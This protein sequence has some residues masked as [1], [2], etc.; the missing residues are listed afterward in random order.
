MD[1]KVSD[2]YIIHCLERLFSPMAKQFIMHNTNGKQNKRALRSA[3]SLNSNTSLT[4]LIGQSSHVSPAKT[5]RGDRGTG[6]GRE[7]G[8]KLKRAKIMRKSQRD[9]RTGRI[10]CRLW[11]I[12][13]E[14]HWPKG[15]PA[16]Q[17]R[18]TRA[19]TQSLSCPRSTRQGSESCGLGRWIT[20]Q[21]LSLCRPKVFLRFHICL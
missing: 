6:V 2:L 7:I 4:I 21:S 10:N 3:R 19:G 11:P 8:K 5:E 16:M 17:P 1:G 13:H 12:N 20:L 14:A 15:C 18:T 9:I